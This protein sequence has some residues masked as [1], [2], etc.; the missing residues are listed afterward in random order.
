M[1]PEYASST[2][3]PYSI[4]AKTGITLC[5]LVMILGIL[6]QSSAGFVLDDAYMFVRYADNF[7]ENGLL[8]WN[9]GGAPVYGLTSILFLAIVIPVRLV[10]PGDPSLAASVSSQLSGLVFVYLMLLLMLRIA[11]TQGVKPTLLILLAI[12][13]LA[14]GIH[15]VASHFVSGMDTMFVM[16]YLA[17][18]V[19]LALRFEEHPHTESAVWLGVVGGCAFLARPDMLVFTLGLPLS[20]YFLHR[21]SLVGKLFGIALL[22]TISVVLIQILWAWSY[23]GYP[24]PLSFLTKG[25]DSYGSFMNHQYRLVPYTEFL[26]YFVSYWF[27]FA[28]IGADLAINTRFWRSRESLLETGILLSVIV[29][30]VYY[31]FFVLQVMYRPQRFYYPTLPVLV[32]LSARGGLRLVR[33]L[34]ASIRDGLSSSPKI[35][36]WLSLVLLAGVLL[37][38][39]MAVSKALFR[40]VRSGHLLH[41]DLLMNYRDRFSD[42]WVGLEH[43]STLPNDLIIATTEVGRVAAL[44][45]H[46]QIVDL[47]GLNDPEIARRGFSSH[48]LLNERKPD[49]IYMPHPHYRER[50]ENIISHRGFEAGYSYFTGASLGSIM[51]VAIR[52]DS[53]FHGQLL[54]IISE[55]APRQRGVNSE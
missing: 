10:L 33:R 9:P 31:L 35:V 47:A 29:F 15:S 8:S 1:T 12:F 41:Y 21:R 4:Q 52:S 28:I 25:M 55:T 17:A 2:E 7:I 32:F 48:Y 42:F 24:L 20:G 30:F 37:G 14:N 11:H 53:K 16:A 38:P 26:K 13:S 45:P 46:K 40:K 6:S 50:I 49:L 5:V 19:L 39:S 43:V 18:Y 23:F 51:G 3:A 27:L 36:R 44:N 54:K 34:P 22:V